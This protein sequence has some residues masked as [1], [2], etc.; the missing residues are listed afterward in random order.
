MKYRLI[1]IDL[2]GT[3]LDPG[4][5]VSD[6]NRRAIAAA[7]DAGA[8]VVPCTGRGWCE[9]RSLLTGIPELELGV[10]ITGASIV[11]LDTGE[12]LDFAVI[13]PHL[14]H[15]LVQSLYHEPESVLVYREA[16]LAGHDYLITGAGSLTPTTQWWFEVGEM[17]VHFQQNVTVDDLHHSLRVGLAAEGRRLP[18]LEQ[19]LRAAFGDRV[20]MH[21]FAAV[22]KPDPDETVHILEI[23]ARGVDKWRGLSWIADQYGIAPHEVAAIGD[24]INDLSMLEAAGCGVAMGN[25]IAPA[26]AAA[27]RVTATNAEHGVAEAIQRMIDGTW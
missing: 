19:R 9:A 23:F 16:D 17:T 1:G 11:R 22:Q 27:N 5:Q 7:R 12:S 15:E 4:G 26:K 18:E 2:D 24:E 20:F 6:E 10:F 8:I 13:E 14:V 21:H 3:L 25:A